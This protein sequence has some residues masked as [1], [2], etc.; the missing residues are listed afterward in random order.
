[1]NSTIRVAA[2]SYRFASG[3]GRILGSISEFLTCRAC[4]PCDIITLLVS[5]GNAL[6]FTQNSTVK[7]PLCLPK[8]YSMA[9]QRPWHADITS[10]LFQLVG[11]VM[12]DIHCP[13]KAGV[14]LPL[15]GVWQSYLQYTCLTSKEGIPFVHPESTNS[16]GWK[17]CPVTLLKWYLLS[18][19]SL[20]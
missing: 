11:D 9:T 18:P 19:S 20:V 5:C 1:M 16:S 14:L 10:I 7:N 2:R 13:T 12:Q 17:K 6:A 8:G 15:M 3:V 4:A